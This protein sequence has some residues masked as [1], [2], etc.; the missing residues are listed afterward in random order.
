MRPINT[1]MSNVQPLRFALSPVHRN[2]NSSNPTLHQ[3]NRI[4]PSI[5]TRNISNNYSKSHR[6]PCFHSA[7]VS[8]EKICVEEEV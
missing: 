3:N 5:K 4:N 6:S 1:Q 8:R 7:N 2:P